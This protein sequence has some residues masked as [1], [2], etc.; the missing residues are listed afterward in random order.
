MDYLKTSAPFWK[1]EERAA[2]ASWVSA[3][4]EDDAAKERWR[5]SPAT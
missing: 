5:R 4:G 1:R 2:G 3:R